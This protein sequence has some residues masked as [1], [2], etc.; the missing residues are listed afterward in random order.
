MST[1]SLLGLE[2]QKQHEQLAV[3]ELERELARQE[4]QRY[5]RENLEESVTS[6][7]APLWHHSVL[8]HLQQKDVPHERRGE[9]LS[10][11]RSTGKLDRPS[12][13]DA[14]V[15]RSCRGEFEALR[16][17]EITG[18]PDNKYDGWLRGTAGT[19]HGGDSAATCTPW[20]FRRK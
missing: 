13:A 18:A 20:A 7:L 11:N 4:Q 1:A 10:R 19:R 5:E 17:E 14:D 9:G 8:Q 16:N 12:P 2:E 15:W 3:A 6:G